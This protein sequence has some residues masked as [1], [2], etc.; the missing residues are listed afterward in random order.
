MLKLYIK[1]EYC[2]T[3]YAFFL[4]G[5]VQSPRLKYILFNQI[6]GWN[7]NWPENENKWKTKLFLCIWIILRVNMFHLNVYILKYTFYLSVSRFFLKMLHYIYYHTSRF[8][9]LY[10]INNSKICFSLFPKAYKGD[11]QCDNAI[12]Y[13]K[14]TKF[15]LKMY[16]NTD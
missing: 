13:I 15:W 1:K 11:H 4:L 9:L 7:W 10:F 3:N 6:Y 12:F 8:Y 14:K 16:I 2:I 5:K